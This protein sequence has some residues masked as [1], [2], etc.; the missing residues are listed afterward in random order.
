[1]RSLRTCVEEGI[2]DG[3]ATCDPNRTRPPSGLRWPPRPADK[4][5]GD[6]HHG[7]HGRDRRPVRGG[8]RRGYHHNLSCRLSWRSR[9]GLPALQA[10]FEGGGALAPNRVRALENIDDLAEGSRLHRIAVRMSLSVPDDPIPRRAQLLFADPGR[11]DFGR[12]RV[13]H[14]PENFSDVISR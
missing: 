11:D 6:L 5:I 14:R 13:A 8:G 1:M 10:L 7:A 3:F 2:A 9:P 4:N 12:E